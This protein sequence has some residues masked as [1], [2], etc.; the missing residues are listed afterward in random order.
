M[1]L[2]FI[3]PAWNEEELIGN[4]LKSIKEGSSGYDFEMIVSDD[5]SDV[6]IFF[7][8]QINKNIIRI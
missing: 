4:T 5:A 8:P 3:L 1:K 2:S 7:Y 6:S